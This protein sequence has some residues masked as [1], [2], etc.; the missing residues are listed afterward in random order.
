MEQKKINNCKQLAKE[1]RRE[2]VV[3]SYGTGKVGVH[4]GPALSLADFLAVLYGGVMNIDPSNPFKE[5]RDRFVLSKGHAYTLR[6]IQSLAFVVFSQQW[7]I[8]KIS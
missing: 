2:I 6:F 5:G 8:M 7:N 4:I 1:L 3:S